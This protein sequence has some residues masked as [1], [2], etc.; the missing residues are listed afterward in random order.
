MN[1]AFFASHA[2]LEKPARTWMTSIGAIAGLLALG[3]PA[4]AAVAATPLPSLSVRDLSLRETDAASTMAN[5][6]VVLSKAV[7]HK[8]SVRYETVNGTARSPSDY[9]RRAG[10]VFFPAGV[11]VMKVSI[12]VNGDTRDEA[13][14]TFRLRISDPGHATIADRSGTVTVRDDDP[15]PAMSIGDVTVTEGDGNTPMDFPVRLSAASG[16]PVSVAYTVESGSADADDDYVADASGVVSF[17]PGQTVRYVAAS[18]VGDT[19]DEVDETF[20]VRL[21]D[22]QNARLTHSSAVGT[23]RDDDGPDLSVENVFVR[24]G[25]T[26]AFEVELSQP[27]KQDVT[28]EFTTE[29]GT[30][31]APYD[32][33]ET[34]GTRTIYAGDREV[35]IRVPT[36]D[37]QRDEVDE[38]FYLD[39]G[40]VKNAEVGDGH[41]FARIDDDD[42]PR[43]WVENESVKEGGT[44]YFK[45]RLSDRSPQ[46]VYFEYRSRDGS[47]RSPDDYRAVLGHKVIR[48][49][50]RGTWIRVETKDDKL[51]EGDETFYLEISRVR[52]ARL[53]GGGAVGTVT[54]DDQAP[55]P[56]P[57]ADPTVSIADVSVTGEASP[58]TLVVSLSKP[59]TKT[60]TVAWATN[61]LSPAS[62]VA[63]QDYT[64][65]SGTL[66][67]NP[68]QTT[69]SVSV[70]I[71]K[72]GAQEQDETF[73]VK[74]DAPT[75]AT[76]G[77]QTVATVTILAN[78]T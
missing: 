60:V 18:A 34:S 58:A 67:F 55:P 74:L 38:T 47:A 61:D 36:R 64:A 59:S 26:A 13:D 66:T 43:L 51:V 72:D 7:T 41:A 39:I 62:A 54:D 6:R 46:D 20:T 77:P 11:K 29:D 8:V 75:N 21:S 23:I 76:P 24:E 22:P 71:A 31:H 27:S 25:H 16:L 53:V 10:R 15:M 4:P 2:P 57:A 44:A 78:N 19:T 65:G 37:D 1:S 70:T 32:Y 42:G 14:E 68:G 12:P 35:W 56:P 45:V 9:V 49:G 30:A 73:Q 33:R 63:G 48:A 17:S 69:R 52:D 28:F 50:D 40:R 5:V 3:L